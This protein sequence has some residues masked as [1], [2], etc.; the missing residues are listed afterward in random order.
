M[1]T[2]QSSNLSVGEYGRSQHQ[3]SSMNLTKTV[4]T[5]NRLYVLHHR[6]LPSYLSFAKPVALRGDDQA[7]ETLEQIASDQS[8]ICDRIGKLIV[9]VGGYIEPGEFP[10]FFTGYHDLSCGFLVEQAIRLQQ[11]DIGVIESCAAEQD[12]LPLAKA[13]AEECL[14]AA[15]GHLELLSELSE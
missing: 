11:R 5:L 1:V 13:L 8:Q 14:G 2:T 15:K 7:P 4:D 9:E 10:M 12:L 6:S 3:V